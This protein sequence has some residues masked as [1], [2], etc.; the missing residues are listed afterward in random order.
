MK[1]NV[2]NASYRYPGSDRYALKN[3]SFSAQP[4]SLVAVLGPNGSGKTTL[5]RCLAGFLRWTE[6]GS[7][8]DGED[9]RSIPPKRLWSL[10]SYVPQARSASP[11]L[12]VRETVLLGRAGRSALTPSE[13]DM[14]AAESAME[15]LGISALADRRCGGLSG[16]ELQ[17]A[18]IAR[19][20]AAE[21]KAVILDEP[22]SN[23][24]FRNQLIILDAMSAMAASGLS[25]IFNTHYPAHA[26]QRADRALLLTKGGGSVFGDTAGIVSEENI[27]SAFGVEAAIGQAEYGGRIVKTVTP[28][29]LI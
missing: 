7:D 22:E 9:I 13:K 27:A 18:L 29:R 10:I 3:V 23:L 17:M 5:L 8:I 24:D 21:P 4:G 6:G 19:A 15:R 12:T 14:A 25:V 2:K 16:G 20:M 1:I 28:V 26:L 11:A